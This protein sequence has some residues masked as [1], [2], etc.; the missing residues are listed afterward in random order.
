MCIRDRTYSVGG[1]QYILVAISD[2]R[3]S[4][5]YLALSLPE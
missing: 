2:P 1:K 4:G 3:Y 5:E